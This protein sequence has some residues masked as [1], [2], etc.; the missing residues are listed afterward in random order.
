MMA[1]SFRNHP[2]THSM[3]EAAMLICQNRVGESTFLAR[4]EAI[5]CTSKRPEKRICAAMPIRKTRYGFINRCL[6][7]CN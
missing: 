2:Y 3:N 1:K 5:H 7:P 4:S 6:S